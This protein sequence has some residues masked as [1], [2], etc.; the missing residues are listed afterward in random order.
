MFSQDLRDKIKEAYAL[1]K[2]YRQVGRNFNISHQTVKY[3]VEKDDTQPKKK[4]G[5]KFTLTRAQELS[6]KR[7]VRKC[8]ATGTRVT[9]SLV[10]RNCAIDSL[11]AESVRLNLRRLGFKHREVKQS[12]VLSRQH[13]EKRVELATKWLE[14][15]HRWSTTIFS[16]EKKFNLDGPDS[17]ST[18]TDEGREIFRQSRQM[19]GGSVM[20][21]AMLLPN[22]TIHIERLIGKIDAKRYVELL[23]SVFPILDNLYGAGHYVFQQDNASIHTSQVATAFFEAQETQLLEW[24]AKSPDLNIIENVWHMISSI[25]YAD[26]QYDDKETLWQAIQEAAFTLMFEKSEQL[27]NLYEDMNKRLLEVIQA[28][29]A[30]IKR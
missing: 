10:K 12:I 19:G 24:P 7:E 29:G 26:K 25:V 28:K 23:T 30:T 11:C 9:A 17:W 16:D 15:G 22:G 27:H 5:P 1:L 14:S 18:Y 8:N 20:V 4:R 3:I 21:W 2:N 6:M 13:K